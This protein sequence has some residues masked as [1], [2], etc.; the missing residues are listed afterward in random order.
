MTTGLY[1]KTIYPYMGVEYE[2][3]LTFGKRSFK[4]I[5]YQAYNALGLIGSECNGLAVFDNNKK[6]VVADQIHQ[7]GTG[8]FGASPEQ[9]A[10][11]GKVINMDWPAF[12]KWVNMRRRLRYS[13]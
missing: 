10:V 5:T 8:W 11:F 1:H 3:D 7:I 12:Q 2:R 6:Q 9:I 13:I 4:I